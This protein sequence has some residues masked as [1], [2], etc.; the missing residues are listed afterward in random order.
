MACSSHYRP[1]RRGTIAMVM[2]GGQIAYD[3]DGHIHRHGVFGGGL[4]EAVRGVPAAEAAA[5]RY[6]GRLAT[7][8]LMMLGGLLCAPTAATVALLRHEEETN[9]SA[10]YLAAGC[11]AL[12]FVG[13]GVVISAVPYQYDAVN[14][15]N[16]HVRENE[17]RNNTWDAP[18]SFG[19]PVPAPPPPAPEDSGINEPPR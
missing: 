14:I 3:R 1:K 6:K 7:G 5:G 8:F 11:L 13:S 9:D 2:K 19:S 17:E 4:S 16:D 12:T 15:F 18:P 10:L